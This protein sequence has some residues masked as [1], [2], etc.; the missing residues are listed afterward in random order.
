M[1]A[2][3][4]RILPLPLSSSE[5]FR[6]LGSKSLPESSPIAP[7]LTDDLLGLAVGVVVF[8]D[9]DFDVDDKAAEGWIAAVLDLM[10]EVSAVDGALIVGE[11]SLS[12]DALLFAVLA[13]VSTVERDGPATAEIVFEHVEV[14]AEAKAECGNNLDAEA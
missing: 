12:K 13:L 4:L 9:G 1:T 8:A 2:C 7:L 6:K 3:D 14:E 11:E 5:S 10:A